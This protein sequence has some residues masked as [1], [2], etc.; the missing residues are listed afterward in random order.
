[1]KILLNRR[2]VLFWNE[3]FASSYLPRP[4]PHPAETQMRKAAQKPLGTSKRWKTFQKDASPLISISALKRSP[5]ESRNS[6]FEETPP[7]RCYSVEGFLP[8]ASLQKASYRSQISRSFL[9]LFPRP[10]F[11][12][13]VFPESPGIAVLILSPACLHLSGQEVFHFFFLFAKL[14]LF[15]QNSSSRSTSKEF[16]P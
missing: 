1:M 14:N 4:P 9:W 15:L 10:D 11:F 8:S 13:Q 3:Y 5:P 16:S 7:P 6:L 12:T 2:F